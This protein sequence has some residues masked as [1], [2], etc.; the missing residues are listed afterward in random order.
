MRQHLADA[1]R[2]LRMNTGV[3][4]REFAAE[5][6]WDASHLSRVERAQVA[7]SRE[8]LDH[9]ATRFGGRELIDS[10]VDAERLERERLKAEQRGRAGTARTDP[11][12]D[13]SDPDD[14]SE[15]IKAEVAP[16]AIVTAGEFFTVTFF[17]RNAGAI[18]WHERFL[19]RAGP[20]ATMAL[21]WSPSMIAIEH[22][23][24][25]EIAEIPIPLRGAPLPGT[26][27]I[28]F[29]M[30]D[31]AGNL[32]FPRKYSYGLLVTVITVERDSADPE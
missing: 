6:S 27:Q 28:L 16:K 32:Y 9:Y 14:A 24:P 10:L 2:A 23:A 5:T 12:K 13:I 17:V 30:T 15:F 25:G 29:K 31:G 21:P 18:P 4:L 22:T 8:L 11:S 20:P 1:L 26:A 19:S 3:K 7:P